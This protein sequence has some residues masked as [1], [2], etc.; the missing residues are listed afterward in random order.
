M[1]RMNIEG[2]ISTSSMVG[3]G[4][5]QSELSPVL[6]TCR[7]AAT[8]PL[9][10]PHAQRSPFGVHAPA[11]FRSTFRPLHR[12][13]QNSSQPAQIFS[14]APRAIPS[15]LP[16]GE[17]ARMRG[18][19]ARSHSPF[20]SCCTG[21]CFRSKPFPNA[22]QA[23]IKPRLPRTNQAYEPFFQGFSSLNKATQGFPENIQ[24]SLDIKASSATNPA[25]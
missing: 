12:H 11:R 20:R 17:K 24:T 21:L 25:L 16:K 4:P 14:D 15:P 10:S 19:F 18:P 13:V 8:C 7:R 23:L 3:R 6:F 22:S 9:A 2:C 1:K 5:S